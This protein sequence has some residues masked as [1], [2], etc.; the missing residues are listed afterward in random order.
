MDDLVEQGG[1]CAKICTNPTNPMAA[2]IGPQCAARRTSP[3]PRR[4]AL[5][6]LPSCAGRRARSGGLRRAGGWFCH[7]RG[8]LLLGFAW[9]GRTLL[10]PG[11]GGCW[12]CWCLEEQDAIVG[13]AMHNVIG[14]PFSCRGRNQ[15]LPAEPTKFPCA[16]LG[17]AISQG[18]CP[19]AA[20]SLPCLPCPPCP[21]LPALPW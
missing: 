21:A 18:S 14:S 12:D 15:L 10:G 1:L 17:P 3:G 16:G 8:V 6:I 5:V 13:L 20:P 2:R 4:R 7:L 19:P 11:W 9:P